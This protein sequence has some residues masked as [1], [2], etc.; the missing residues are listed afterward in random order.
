[1][2]NCKTTKRNLMD[3][4]LA[5]TRA[6]SAESERLAEEL[7]GCG[8]CQAEYA[9]LRRT[10]EVVAQAAQTATPG[11]I[12]WPGY[13]SRLASRLK[14][15]ASTNLT[16]LP[17]PFR[18]SNR[19][20]SVARKLF[21]ASVRIPLPVAAVL[22]LSIGLSLVLLIKV[23]GQ[24]KQESPAPAIAAV[25]TIEVPIIRERVVTRVVYVASSRRVGP[26]QSERT[27]KRGSLGERLTE[28]SA[29]RRAAN[30][31]GF[32]PT[33]QVK[34]TIIKGSYRDEK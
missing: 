24:S 33:D 4:A 20:W 29:N 11:E 19:Q 1:M 10:L 31:S 27:G 6:R 17:V 9:S 8:E 5:E 32:R 13:H 26:A 3:L 34:L 18:S 30:L 16:A 15:A 23:R 25:K 14:N 21:G 28:E 7:A 12:F 2:H 22:V